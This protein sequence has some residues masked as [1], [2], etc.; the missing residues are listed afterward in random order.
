MTFVYIIF[1]LSDVLG[2]KKGTYHNRYTIIGAM[3]LRTQLMTSG[4]SEMQFL[5]VC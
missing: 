4:A 1:Q 2:L 3:V 5:K